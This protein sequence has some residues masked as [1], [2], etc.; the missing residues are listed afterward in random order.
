MTTRNDITQDKIQS[1]GSSQ[2]YREG[3]DSIFSCPH[4]LTKACRK[5]Y[6]ELTASKSQHKRISSQTGQYTQEYSADDVV[7]S[8]RDTQI[9]GNMAGELYI[10]GEQTIEY[11]SP[12]DSQPAFTHRK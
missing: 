9:I 11:I 2:A 4:L 3:F 12:T 6:T 7:I 10:I 1:K 5:R 8:P